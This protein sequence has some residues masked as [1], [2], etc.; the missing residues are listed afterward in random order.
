VYIITARDEGRADF[1]RQWLDAHGLASHIRDLIAQDDRPDR[2]KVEVA[3]ELGCHALIEDDSRHLIPGVLPQL[4]HLRVGMG[5][6]VHV[7]DARVVCSTWLD[8]V[9][10]LTEGA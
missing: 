6:P 10:L 2:P 8:A 7:S 3:K 4:V 1:S 5:K 9:S